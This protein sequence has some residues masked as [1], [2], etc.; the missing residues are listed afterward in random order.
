MDSP[1][2]FPF[3]LNV[4]LDVFSA[5]ISLAFCMAKKGEAQII[6][7]GARGEIVTIDR[8]DAFASL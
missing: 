7:R 2:S 6:S 1:R 5:F 8:H 3:P 4:F